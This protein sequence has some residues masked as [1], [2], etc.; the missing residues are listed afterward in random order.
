[1]RIKKSLIYDTDDSVRMSNLFYSQSPVF[2][3]VRNDKK[4][5]NISQFH[6][7]CFPVGHSH[8]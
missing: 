8:K 4:N 3:V 7:S 5:Q 2:G 1:M 6:A